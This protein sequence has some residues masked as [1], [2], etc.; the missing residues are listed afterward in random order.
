[1]LL[2][3]PNRFFRSIFLFIVIVLPLFIGRFSIAATLEDIQSELL[4]QLGYNPT[5]PFSSE[6]QAV[7]PDLDNPV[8]A[9][10][11]RENG[12]EPLW[13]T[14]EGPTLSASV[15]FKY[16][17]SSAD[18]GLNPNDYQIA[19]I[20]SYWNA[21]DSTSLAKI[22]I[23]L[24]TALHAYV[25][26]V[27]EGRIDPCLK[28][29]DLFTCARDRS[30]DPVQ[31]IS[32]ALAAKDFAAFMESQPPDTD[33]YR[34]LKNILK[35]Y[36]GIEKNGGWPSI[37]EGPTLKP[38]D[39]DQ[40]IPV[41]RSRLTITNDLASENRSGDPTL[42]DD[43]LS[44][45]VK[46]FQRRHGLDQDGIIG[47]ETRS[48]MNIP[49]SSKISKIIVNMER[50][51]WISRDLGPLYVM[52]NIAGFRLSVFSKSNLELEMPVIVGKYYRKTPVFSS[53]I[54]YIELNP[55]WNIPQSI[56]IKDILPKLKKDPDYLSDQQI[57]LFDGWKPDA[58]ELDP[59]KIKWSEITSS[60]MAVYKLRQDPGPKNS[61]GRIKFMLPNRFAVY[62]HDTP[63]QDLFLR[64]QRTFSSGCIRLS[65]PLQL[66]AY[67]LGNDQAGWDKAKIQEVIESG[68]RRIISLKTPVPIH[69]VYLTVTTEP[70]GAIHFNKDIY[71]RDELLEKALLD[72]NQSFP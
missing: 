5:D 1:M 4:E 63:A 46:H 3:N 17:R 20:E 66:A 54:R 69:V 64:T 8:M 56:A 14:P 53:Y 62:L 49:V 7:N 16:L 45:A 26:D 47:Q 71:G 19:R 30:I 33:Q 10:V 12:F 31:L 6:S 44:T 15:L 34:E 48:A 25:S 55:Y 72:E 50:L 11:Y 9:R 59:S 68:D 41:I 32:D 35:F 36:R 37:P 70:D 21:T 61:L 40:R 51:R 65:H 23:L 43:D 58:H 27:R 28:D 67:L 24:T 42:Y 18:E 38:G 60:K 13:V 52:V 39:R 29:P 2:N 22:D 57:R